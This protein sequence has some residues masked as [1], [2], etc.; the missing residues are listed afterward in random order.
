MY[1]SNLV[2]YCVHMVYNMIKYGI[3]IEKIYFREYMRRDCFLLF[4]ILSVISD[5]SF[6]DNYREIGFL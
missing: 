4:N 2:E 1:T 3:I 6:R 5:C